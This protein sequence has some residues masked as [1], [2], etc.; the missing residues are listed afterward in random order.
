MVN[1][2]EANVGEGGGAN[3]PVTFSFESTLGAGGCERHVAA[4]NAGRSNP[5]SPAWARYRV[6]WSSMIAESKSAAPVF[7]LTGAMIMRRHV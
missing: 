4:A 5:R 6:G 1:M 3:P 2:Q 7:K